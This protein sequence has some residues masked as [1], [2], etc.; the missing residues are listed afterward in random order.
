MILVFCWIKG[1][2]VSIQ[3]YEKVKTKE[4]RKKKTETHD[5]S[6]ISKKAEI[7]E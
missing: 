7:Y 5:T 6:Q 1:T 3:F 2:W 4:K